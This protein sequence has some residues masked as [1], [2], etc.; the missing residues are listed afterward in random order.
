MRLPFKM[1][2][3][4]YFLSSGWSFRDRDAEDWMS[5]PVVPSVVQQDLIANKKWVMIL[6]LQMVDLA[7]DMLHI[8]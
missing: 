2:V 5:V 1:E 3:N 7:I 4:R 8:G 6:Y